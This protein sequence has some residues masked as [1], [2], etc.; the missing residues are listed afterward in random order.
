MLFV[1]VDQER[2]VEWFSLE[3]PRHNPL[4]LVVGVCA[5]VLDKRL[6]EPVLDTA[7]AERVAAREA[8]EQNAAMKA[9]KPCET[10][11]CCDGDEDVHVWVPH[12]LL[13]DLAVHMLTQCNQQLW[14]V[15]RGGGRAETI[16]AADLAV[17]RR[18]FSDNGEF[19]GWFDRR[20]GYSL[21][22]PA[23]QSSSVGCELKMH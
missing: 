17:H 12:L 15:V 22:A 2:S 7:L 20:V 21:R 3:V 23:Y 6:T 11:V 13:A 9:W 1:R 5:E 4:Q 10:D 16:S 19:R 18:R 8:I 14:R